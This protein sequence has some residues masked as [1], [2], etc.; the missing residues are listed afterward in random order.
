MKKLLFLC[1]LLLLLGSCKSSQTPSHRKKLSQYQFLHENQGSK[2]FEV[3]DLIPK[4]QKVHRFRIDTVRKQL[5][6]IG[7]PYE[8]WKKDSS[9][10]KANF[11]GDTTDEYDDIG[12]VLLNNG[13]YLDPA[14]GYCNWVVNGDRT[15]YPF[16]QLPFPFS[17]N[18]WEEEYK[19]YINQN[20]EEWFKVFEEY[21]NKAEYVFLHWIGYYF[22][23]QGKWYWMMDDVL[24]D[25][26][27]SEFHKQYPSRETPSRFVEPKRVDPFYTPEGEIQRYDVEIQDYKE[28]DRE[29]GT[30]FRPI[31]YSAGIFYYTL[32]LSDEDVIYIKRFSPM[33]PVTRFIE[34]PTEYGGYGNKVLF[35]E[36]I[37]NDFYPDQ[38]FGGLYAIRPR[39]KP[40]AK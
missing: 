16:I 32:R 13:V 29:R 2:N 27:R 35:I 7:I 26:L 6:I 1:S 9:S 24:S 17:I 12:E 38:A 31:E 39:K 40:L 5:L 10:I 3:V 15:W 36:Q 8:E 25:N 21:Y 18:Y 22:L 33:T 30:W 14:K 37:P 28:K 20:F 4:E 11:Y 19:T 23:Y 34:I